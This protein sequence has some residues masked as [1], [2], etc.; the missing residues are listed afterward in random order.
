MSWRADLPMRATRLR[1]C[2][3]F[4]LLEVLIA[5]LVLAL[6]LLALTRTAA[7]QVNQFDQLR[8]R[9]L[10]GWLAQQVLAET[11]IATAFPELSKNDGQRRFA[12]REWRWQ[13]EVQSTDVPTIRRIDV[14]V[15][16]GAERTVP[17][18]ELTGFAGT[19]LEP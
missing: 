16:L 11:R 15:Y 12:D 4:T 9:T 8:S 19:D 13:T 10:A 1:A 2:A 14:K 6:A 17:L 5:L 18:A 7:L 3:G